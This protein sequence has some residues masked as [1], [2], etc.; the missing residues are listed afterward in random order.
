MVH[1]LTGFYLFFNFLKTLGFDFLNQVSYDMKM[2]HKQV[3]CCICP[4]NDTD[5]A[6]MQ[7]TLTQDLGMYSMNLP[8]EQYEMCSNNPGLLPGDRMTQG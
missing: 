5:I 6:N 3:M 2:L 8:H 1:S 7:I 4:V